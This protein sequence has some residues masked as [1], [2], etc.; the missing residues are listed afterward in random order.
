MAQ[1]DDITIA[2]HFIDATKKV[3]STMAGLEAV[4]GKPFSLHGRPGC[5]GDISAIIGVTGACSGS[6]S[7]SFS[8]EAALT[9]LQ[10]MLGEESYSDE[11]AM[12]AVGEI[13]NMISGT[14]RASLSEAGLVMQ[15]STPSVISGK[16]HT[17]L[18]QGKNPG[19]AIPFTVG[20]A[21]F[22]VEFTLAPENEA[23]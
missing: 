1:K 19:I 12:D 15:G 16:D 11:E 13:I 21:S 23:N 20:N 3:L 6:I 10:G 17:I 7:V 8:K 18:H 2:K 4:S 14:A 5:A 22:N 9:V